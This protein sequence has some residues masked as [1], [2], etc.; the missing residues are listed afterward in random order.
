MADGYFRSTRSPG[1][2]LVGRG[3]SLTN[4]TNA[5]ITAVKANSGILV[6]GGALPTSLTAD[7]EGARRHILTAKSIDQRAYFES[8]GVAVFEVT[9]ASSAAADFEVAYQTAAR[10]VPVALLIPTD[11]SAAES[12]D[13]PASIDTSAWSAK[14]A[15]EAPSDEIELIASILDEG[16][17]A[18]RPLIL[19]GKGA[20]LSHARDDLIE[21]ADRIGAVLATSLA[22]RGLFEGHPY[23]IGISGTMSSAIAS[24]LISKS[25]VVLA[26]G[27][28]LNQFTTMGGDLLQSASI[29]HVDSD[30][31]ALGLHV[32]LDAGIHGDARLV[33][34]QLNDELDRRGH[35]A[36]SSLRTPEIATRIEDESGWSIESP[37]RHP[38][39]LDPREALVA[40]DRVLPRQ[41]AVV[42]DGGAV[43]AFTGH[44]LRPDGPTSFVFNLDYGSVG[45]G[46]C[47]AL[48]M[49]V[50]RNDRP[51][52][53]GIGDGGFMFSVVNDLD[54][55]VRYKLRLVVIVLDDGGF[56]QE[57]HLLDMDGLPNDIAWY[58]NPSFTAVSLALG[59]QAVRLDALEDVDR[60]ADLVKNADGPVVIEVPVSS[61]RP[62]ATELIMRLGHRL[63]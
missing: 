37:V 40:L 32:D 21:L 46:F 14:S 53:V 51:T 59:A 63:P 4:G 38:D 18:R 9:S 54:T 36:V 42:A 43:L 44:Y 41:R 19:A 12:G 11:V 7:P 35:V 62:D 2:V 61:V 26:F 55:A 16:W 24:E 47:I 60:V 28:S 34:R 56:G 15:G 29:V 22:A 17:L 50:A 3:P 52:V 1:V 6:V 48:G 13:D 25:T 10:G 27:A 58:D 23:D 20:V 8:L 5:Y 39:R 30:A 45:A 49:A 31:S 57:A 33:A